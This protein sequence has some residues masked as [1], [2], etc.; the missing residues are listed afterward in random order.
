MVC[1]GSILELKPVTDTVLEVVIRIK[2]NDSYSVIAFTAYKEIK[3]LIQQV[4]IEKGDYVKVQFN[5]ISKKWQD[6]YYLA[7]Y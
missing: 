6:K 7:Q 1:R 5:L 3:I 4:K 2:K